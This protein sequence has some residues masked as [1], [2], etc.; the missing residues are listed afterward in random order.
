MFCHPSENR[1]AVTG[2]G[3]QGP[4]HIHCGQSY[5]GGRLAAPFKARFYFYPSSSRLSS[6]HLLWS[7]QIT[8]NAAIAHAG[9]GTSPIANGQPPPPPA[10]AT[11]HDIHSTTPMRLPPPRTQPGL[12]H[13]PQPRPRTRMPHQARKHTNHN[14]HDHDNGICPHRPTRPPQHA[15]NARPGGQNES[16]S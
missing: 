15:P 6:S 3:R 13:T 14:R 7:A 5:P 16:T 9:P 11:A 1:T 4:G 10:I 8:H 2:G 12:T